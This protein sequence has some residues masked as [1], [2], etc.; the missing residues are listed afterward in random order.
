MRVGHDPPFLRQLP[1]KAETQLDKE[2]KGSGEKNFICKFR[3]KGL[4]VLP[5]KKSCQLELARSEGTSTVSRVAFL[6]VGQEVRS[7]WPEFEGNYDNFIAS[8]AIS[9]YSS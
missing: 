1:G 8:R 4:D 9:G 3:G 2:M 6:P 7:A 5:G